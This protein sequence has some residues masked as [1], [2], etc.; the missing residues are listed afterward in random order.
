MYV[1]RSQIVCF[2]ENKM[3]INIDLI[4]LLRDERENEKHTTRIPLYSIPYNSEYTYKTN[5]STFTYI[6]ER[7]SFFSS[8]FF[9]FGLN[10]D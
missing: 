10:F 8:F 9:R 4:L 2:I 6:R 5:E 1:I 7:K 3:K